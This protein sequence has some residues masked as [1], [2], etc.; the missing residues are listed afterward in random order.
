[1]KPAVARTM[2][3][4]TMQGDGGKPATKAKRRRARKVD[5]RDGHDGSGKSNYEEETTMAT[6]ITAVGHP[7]VREN[8]FN[9]SKERL[10]LGLESIVDL[11]YIINTVTMHLI[12]LFEKF[13]ETIFA[14]KYREKTR[15]ALIV[16][17]AQHSTT[18]HVKSLNN[19]RPLRRSHP[20]SGFSSA[21]IL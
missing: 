15:R 13:G 16:R 18:H 17:S 4:A 12:C 2:C 10:N 11:A 1:M 19:G 14:G 8:Q 21:V 5:Y 6:I 3:A 7:I 9:L 20:G